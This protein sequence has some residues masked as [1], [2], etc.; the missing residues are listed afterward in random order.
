MLDMCDYKESQ[1][2]EQALVSSGTRCMAKAVGHY[3]V[4]PLLCLQN[5]RFINKA[6]QTVLHGLLL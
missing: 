4:A 2:A 6:Q 1:L 3:L 5:V